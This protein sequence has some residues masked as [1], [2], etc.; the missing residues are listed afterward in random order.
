MSLDLFMKAHD[1]RPNILIEDDI[2]RW[3][4]SSTILADHDTRSLPSVIV[5]P[6]VATQTAQG[7]TPQRRA[8]ARRK[9]RRASHHAQRTSRTAASAPRC[10]L[11]RVPTAPTVR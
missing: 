10:P 5:P 7:D 3:R 11:P 8:A 6:I 9:S 4:F 1:Q 2:L